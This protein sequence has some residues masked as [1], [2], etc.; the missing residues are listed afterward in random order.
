METEKQKWHGISQI[1]FVLLCCRHIR[2][3]REVLLPTTV[4]ITHHC[5]SVR[6]IQLIN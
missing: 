3:S 2:A 1:N 5:Q 4:I 6:D